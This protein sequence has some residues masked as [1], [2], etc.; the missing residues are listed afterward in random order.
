MKVC[1]SKICPL[2]PPA[3]IVKY[4]PEFDGKPRKAWSMRDSN[5]SPDVPTS[6]EKFEEMYKMLGNGLPY[7]GIIYIDTQV[8]EEILKVIGPIYY[9]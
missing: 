6:A 2:T 3:P 5:L 7:D 9:P 4:L 8:V 1:L